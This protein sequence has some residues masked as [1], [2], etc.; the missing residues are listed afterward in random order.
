MHMTIRAIVY[1]DSR[2]EAISSAERIFQELTENEKPFDYYS[3]GNRDG[4]QA[5]AFRASSIEGKKLIER[6]ME[7]TIRDFKHGL[8]EIR[9][10]IDKPLE[11]LMEDGPETNHLWRY[12]CYQLG[13][14]RGPAVWMYDQDGEGIRDPAH[15]EHV[16]TKWCCLHEDK[17]QPNPYDSLEI[18]VVPA[19]VHH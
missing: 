4:S 14:Y 3:L 12:H 2:E 9:K 8:E 19:D 15:L 10:H 7:L 18:W 11:V 6:G 17:G 13:R 1:A 5:D 16:L